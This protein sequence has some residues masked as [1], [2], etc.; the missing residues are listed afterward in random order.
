MS[1]KIPAKV[2]ARVLQQLKK[3]Q[4]MIGDAR[5][6]DV[7]ESDTAVL[8]IDIL[9]DVLGYKKVVEITAE[10]AVR[11]TFADIAVRVENAVR[12]LVEVK[13]VN[14][15][16]K[17]SHVTQVVNYAANLPA[18]WVILTNGAR[19]QAYKITFGKPIDRIL[20]LDIDLCTA[21]LKGSEVM[22]FFGDLSREVFTRDSMSEMFRAKQAM[23]RYSIAALLIS[24]PIVSVVRRELRKLADGLNPDVDNI[25]CVI[26]EQVIKRELMESDEAKLA[27]KAVRKLARQQKTQKTRTPEVQCA[28]TDSGNLQS[29]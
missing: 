13:A 1:V 10:H 19:W 8:V 9:A 14:V 28:V 5:K 6:R 22:E 26:Q 12:F 18:D 11:G 15:E 23:S 7:N 2:S 25:R 20:V 3:Y 21:N 27:Q 4:A 16:L 24:D 17:E 29:V